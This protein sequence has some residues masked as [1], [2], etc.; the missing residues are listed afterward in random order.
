MKKVKIQFADTGTNGIIE[1]F[2]L[3]ILAKKWDVEI[4]TTP[5]YLFCGDFFTYEFLQ[6]D[7]IKI[8]VCGENEYPNFNLY[9]Y[10]IGL[11][12]FTFGDRYI[13]WPFYLWRDGTRKEFLMACHKQTKRTP[14]KKFCNF[15]VSNGDNADPYREELFRHLN[16]YKKVDSGGRYLN[17]LGYCVEDKLRFIQDYKFTL[18]CENSAQKGY[19]T[20][21]IVE[22]WAAGTVPIYWGAPD[23]CEEFNEKAFIN[24]MAYKNIDDVVKRVK[25]ID[26]DDKKYLEILQEPIMTFNSNAQ[27]FVDDTFLLDFLTNIFEKPQKEAVK[28]V[29]TARNSVINHEMKNLIKYDEYY[30][31]Q[32][33]WCENKKKGKCL[34]DF[35]A[36]KN[37]QKI[38]VYGFGV[39]GQQLIDELTEN[40]KN[41]QMI[42]D[43]HAK[44]TEYKEIPIYSLKNLGKEMEKTD[45]I[46]LT[47][48]DDNQL[49]KNE[50]QKYFPLTKI[51]DLKHIVFSIINCT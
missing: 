12:H 41:I 19:I 35:P 50:I 14:K 32:L 33:I 22:A 11:N 9:D 30:K 27:K 31:L 23:I 20:E 7:C 26:S 40:Q 17:N 5:D 8:Y 38:S 39:L 2:I 47:V 15:V 43:Q 29:K 24:C 28:V 48:K 10:V 45:L 18:A 13:R 44:S 6:Y 46:I 4:S 51:L 16:E 42:I 34:I 21:K 37:A 36:I 49:I 3:E 1:K 25:E